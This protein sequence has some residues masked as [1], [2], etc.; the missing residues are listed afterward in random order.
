ME[1]IISTDQK[2]SHNAIPSNKVFKTIKR[3][4]DENEPSKQQ[5]KKTMGF[6]P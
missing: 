6:H 3:L 1:P 2:V 4:L 5:N